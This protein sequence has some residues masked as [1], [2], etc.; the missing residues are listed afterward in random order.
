[1][2]LVW[3]DGNFGNGVPRFQP[4]LDC[5]GLFTTVGCDLGRPLLW[6]RHAQRLAASLVALG[7][8]D[9]IRLPTERDLCR[10]L[11]ASGIEGM[12]RLRV[13]VGRSGT[14]EWTVEASVTPCV[15]AGATLPPVCLTIVRW[16]APPPLA[17]HKTLSR[18]PWEVAREQARGSNFDDALIVDRED[19]LLETSSA[20]IWVVA[21]GV[22]KTPTAPNQCLP[23]VMRGWLLEH[24]DAIGLAPEVCT[25]T[26]ADLATAD[27]VWCSNAIV[28]VRRVA[29]LGDQRWTGWPRFEALED[30]EIPAPGWPGVRRLR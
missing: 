21:D 30:L 17:G 22:A 10:L 28:G 7:A 26:T 16:S 3:R 29:S 1:M 18:M 15:E 27:E 5:W 8:G 2:N 4:G 20:N 12:A 25:L 24:L 9:G 23:G 14:A 13:V 6:P 19:N 11:E